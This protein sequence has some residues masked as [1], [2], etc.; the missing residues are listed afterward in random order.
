M[1][2]FSSGQRWMSASEPE[3][4]LGTVMQVAGDRV[5]MIF[6]ATGELRMYASESAPL[7]RVQFEVGQEVENQE[8]AKRIVV[9]IR[10]E[11]GVLTYCG[12]EWELPEAH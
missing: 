4:G 7:Q 6:P 5:Q 3:L 11:D 8:G 10:D 2:E 9:S 1:S 12:D